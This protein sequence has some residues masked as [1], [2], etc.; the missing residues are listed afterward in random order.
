MSV[1]VFIS[2]R[3]QEFAKE[4][5]GVARMLVNDMGLTP[6]YFE[7]EPTGGHLPGWCDPLIAKWIKILPLRL[8]P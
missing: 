4:R 5:V 3:I 6:V 8:E 2:S 1:K 7:G